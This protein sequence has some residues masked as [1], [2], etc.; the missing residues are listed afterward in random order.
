MPWFVSVFQPF[1]YNHIVLY[2]IIMT[3]TRRS[4]SKKTGQQKLTIA[5]KSAVHSFGVRNYTSPKENGIIVIDSVRPPLGDPY[6]EY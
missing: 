6:F 5:I 4:L 2:Y 1:L 3:L